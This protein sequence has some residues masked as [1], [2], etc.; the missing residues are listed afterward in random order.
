MTGEKPEEKKK[1][2]SMF[3]STYVPNFMLVDKPAQYYQ[4][5]PYVKL[6]HSVDN[7]PAESVGSLYPSLW[8]NRLARS[9]VNRKVGGSNP[10]RDDLFYQSLRLRSRFAGGLGRNSS[11]L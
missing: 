5:G 10:P 6:L 1:K 8:R 4:I 3:W 11:Q 2:K 7:L 9:A